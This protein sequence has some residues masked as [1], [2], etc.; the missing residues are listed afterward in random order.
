MPDTRLAVDS[1]FLMNLAHPKDV[2]LDA[3]EVIHRRLRGAQILAVPRVVKELA[4]KVIKEPDP[5]KRARARRALASMGTWGICSVE[6]TDLQKTIARSIAGKLLDQGI[7]P[8]EERND[9]LI[10]AEAAFT[11]CNMLV[12]SDAHLLH[13]DRQRL[14]TL[15][16]EHGI[17]APVILSPWKIVSGF[18]GK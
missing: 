18:S 11:R 16:A 3:L 12:T 6:L 2:A 15:F 9:A 8:P 1:N 7:I 4:I 10:L 13:I 17:G 14:R 5:E